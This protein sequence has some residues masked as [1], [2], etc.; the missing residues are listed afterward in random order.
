MTESL[1]PKDGYAVSFKLSEP[2]NFGSE[3]FSIINIMKPRVKHMRNLPVKMEEASLGVLF[4]VAFE[5]CDIRPREAFDSMSP[6]D[7]VAVL[8]IVNHFLA[9]GQD[10]PTGV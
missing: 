2:I 7:G 8:G 6:E 3:M 10:L 9:G 4:D 1:R 5:I